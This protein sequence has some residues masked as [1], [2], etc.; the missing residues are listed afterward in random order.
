M[1]RSVNSNF[2]VNFKII[3]YSKTENTIFLE[4]GLYCNN[5]YI[6][7]VETIIDIL[8]MLQ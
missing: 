1:H 4:L 8:Y 2:L 3:Q 5:R 6:S 7:I